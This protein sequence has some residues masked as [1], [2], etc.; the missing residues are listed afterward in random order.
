MRARA[1]LQGLLCSHFVLCCFPYLFLSSRFH[2]VICFHIHFG[3]VGRA[4][5][6]E[7]LEAGWVGR[8]GAGRSWRR[9]RI[10]S[11]CIE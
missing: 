3:G 10:G 5:R 7:M 9:K 11:K 8:W 6:R 1:G 4:R 2:L